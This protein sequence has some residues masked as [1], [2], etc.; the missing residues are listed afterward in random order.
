MLFFV[1]SVD[2]SRLDPVSSRDN[3]RIP[4]GINRVAA[5]FL[6]NLVNSRNS[7]IVREESVRKQKV[8]RR[9]AENLWVFLY[10]ENLCFQSSLERMTA[11]S[12]VHVYMFS[13][14]PIF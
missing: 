5:F 12:T 1:W 9:A 11:A 8:G 10:G 14:F 4:S 2:S 7:K 6:E 3:D 13:L